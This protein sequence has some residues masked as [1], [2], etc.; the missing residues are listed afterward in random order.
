MKLCD[1][2]NS[3]VWEHL[4]E[5]IKG[6]GTGIWESRICIKIQPIYR[7]ANVGFKKTKNI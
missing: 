3:K 2:Q 5:R 6:P 4:L 1:P 7:Q